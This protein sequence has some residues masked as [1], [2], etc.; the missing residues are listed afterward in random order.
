MEKSKVCDKSKICKSLILLNAI[1]FI[2][3]GV[4]CMLLFQSLFDFILQDKLTIHKG[5]PAYD[6]WKKPSIPTKL[7]WALDNNK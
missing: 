1:F 3:N 4:F 6:N 5:S 2:G 7:K